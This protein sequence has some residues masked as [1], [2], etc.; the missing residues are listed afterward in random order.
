MHA[1]VTVGTAS[2]A[3]VR[4]AGGAATLSASVASDTDGGGDDSASDRGSHDGDN[5]NAA[6]DDRYDGMATP[7]PEQV[8]YLQAFMSN[9]EALEAERDT[10]AQIAMQ[11]SAAAHL[12]PNG[13]VGAASPMSTRGA[14]SGVLNAEDDDDDDDDDDGAGSG[15]DAGESRWRRQGD[16]LHYGAF[17]D[18]GDSDADDGLSDVASDDSDADARSE[19]EQD[20]QQLMAEVQQLRSLRAVSGRVAS[21]A[22]CFSPFA[23]GGHVQLSKLLLSLPLPP[24][25]RCVAREC[26]CCLN[27]ETCWS[28]AICWRSRRGR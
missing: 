13:S 16:E 22:L 24:L 9:L 19:S 15:P 20:V 12:G 23:L 2:Y 26:S 27:N 25:T 28:L 4:E 7:T 17:S 6:D 18:L 8:A 3:T 11:M 1:D 14:E 5:D 21:W 10:L